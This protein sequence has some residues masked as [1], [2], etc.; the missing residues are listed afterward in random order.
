LDIRLFTKQNVA[1]KEKNTKF[2]P[3]I[4]PLLFREQTAVP[5]P[6][7]NGNTFCCMASKLST[8]VAQKDFSVCGAA[9]RQMP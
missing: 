7:R 4:N 6:D 3:F 2:N 5:K 1:P 8:T 9:G